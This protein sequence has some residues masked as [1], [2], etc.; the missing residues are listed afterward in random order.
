MNDPAIRAR[1][2]LEAAVETNARLGHENLGFLSESHGFMPCAQ[3]LLHLPA[4]HRVWDDMAARLPQLFRDLTLRPSLDQM[5]FLSADQ[6]DLPDRYLLRAS[7][8]FSI[9]AQAYHYVEPN[10]PE[11]MPDSLLRPWDQISRRLHRPAPHLSFI[12]M[13]LYNWKLIDPQCADPMRIENLELLIPILGN[14]DERRFQTSAVEVVAQFTPVVGAIVR[15]QEAVVCDDVNALKADLR[16]IADTLARLTYESFMKINPNVYSK[17]YVN[18]V[19]WGKTVAP[20][21]TPFQSVDAPPGPSGTAIPAFQLLDAFFGRHKYASNIGHETARAR[22]WFPKHWQEFLDAVEQISVPEYVAQ[23]RDTALKGRYQEAL[24]GYA[25]ETGLL[26]RHRLKTY[27]FL[28]LS[29]KAGRSKTLGGFGGGFDDRLW[30]KVDAELDLARLERFTHYPLAHHHVALKRIENLRADERE[31]V[32]HVVLDVSGTG[33]RYQPGDRCA[34]LPENSDE[35]IAR[36]LL[37]LRAR[38]DEPIQLNA[39]WREAIKLREGYAGA[40]VLPLRTLLAFGRIRPVGRPIAKALYTITHNERLRR[41]VE[42]RAED[43]WELWQLLDMLAET[44]LNP[45][46]LWKAHPG[47][48]E[49]ICWIIPPE[50]FRMYSISSAMDDSDSESAAEVHLTVGRLK[51]HTRAT[52]VSP[53]DEHYGTSSGFLARLAETPDKQRR[54]ITIKKV[55]PPRFSLPGDVS[56]PIVMFAGGTGLAPFRGLLKQ[57]ARQASAG[58]NWLFFGTRSRADFYYQQ[59]L[60]DQIAQGQLNIRVAFSQ[61]DVCIRSADGRLAVESDTR[62]YIDEEMLREENARQ[63]WR[64]LQ[65]V[66]DGG[67]GACLYICGR[68]SFAQSVL[69]AIQAILYRFADGPDELRYEQARQHLYRLVGEDR[70]MLEIFTTYAGPQFEQRRTY[71]ASEVVSH[72]N[73]QDGYWMIISGRVYDLTEFAHLHPGGLKIIRSY[74]GMDAT[75]AYQKVLHDVNS[76]VDAMLGLYEIGAVRRLDFGSAWSV[77]VSPQGLQLV[78]LKDIYRAWIGLLYATVEMENALHNDYG[79]REEPVTY[80]ETVSSSYV[81][82]YKAQLLLQTHQRFMRDYLAKFTGEPLEHLWTLISG[83]QSEHLD[84]RWMSLTIGTIEQTSEAQVASELGQNI[85]AR[86]K[87]IGQ[88]DAPPG[89]QALQWCVSC[90]TMLEE[91]DKRFLRDI[92]LALRAGVQVFEQLESKTI[93]RGSELLLAAVTTLPEVL[94]AYYARIVS[95]FSQVC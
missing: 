57:R 50:S 33:I 85:A 40:K 38:G 9:F 36:T 48:R 41:I 49:S 86:L 87:A 18:P 70:L 16:L 34:I 8:I 76:E 61:D 3:P 90:C 78:T 53:G 69:G 88:L 80:D 21:A 91:E 81:S 89:A 22:H 82:P 25:G 63:L 28:D 79:I 17:L 35:L 51:Y 66:E 30:D 62:H 46:R 4:S 11:R 13:N 47:E 58:D 59:E 20:L 14:E 31:S 94:R 12:D 56:Q 29:F 6:R 39:A 55:H 26:G 83:L 7:A 65:R 52:D 73:D 15:A 74:A 42:A 92:K 93:A 2:V 5:P 10:P 37:A 43:Q 24:E 72:N 23:H 60:N 1:K 32:S 68:T 54:H 75:A 45:K 19:V 84:V 67:L 44:G 77:A 27:G 64:L 71:D 95:R